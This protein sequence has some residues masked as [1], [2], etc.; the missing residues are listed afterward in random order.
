MLNQY[1]LNVFPGTPRPPK[2]GTRGLLA[3]ADP[4]RRLRTIDCARRG[5]GGPC[6]GRLPGRPSPPGAGALAPQALP[7]RRLLIFATW[8]NVGPDPGAGAGHDP[9]RRGHA[10]RRD[11]V[12]GFFAPAHRAARLR[13][14][15]REGPSASV[16]L[17]SGEHF[18]QCFYVFLAFCAVWLKFL[19][20]FFSYCRNGLRLF[21][22]LP[23]KFFE[24]RA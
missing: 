1:G 7:A 22:C 3:R 19:K 24:K 20:K 14:G 6:G 10:R 21:C 15:A 4:R 8:R 5:V 16:I 2:S 12:I 18:L 23:E 9:G 11:R 13:A 17:R